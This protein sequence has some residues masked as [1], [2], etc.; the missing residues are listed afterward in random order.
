LYQNSYE[1]IVNS[2]QKYFSGNCKKDTW[3]EHVF[4]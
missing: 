4:R 2:P 1:A 3:K